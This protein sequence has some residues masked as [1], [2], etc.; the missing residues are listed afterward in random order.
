MLVAQIS[1]LNMSTF[2]KIFVLV[3]TV[4]GRRLQNDIGR[5][6]DADDQ[7]QNSFVNADSNS[8]RSLA[9]SHRRV[10]AAGVV[11]TSDSSAFASFLLS[12]S[13]ATSSSRLGHPVAA[14]TVVVDS[15]SRTLD[16]RLV[17]DDPEFVKSMLRMR[18]SS[19]E[20]LEI[21]DRIG[22]LTR[23]RSD[24]VQTGDDARK[25]RKQLSGQI[26]ACMKSGD[27]EQAEA[28]KVQVSEAAQTA[29]DADEKLG[30]LDSERSALFASLPN[31]LDPR[32]EDGDDE[33]SN[34][35]VG[36]WGVDD[37]QKDR[38]W[39]DEFG[40]ELGGIDL[41]SAAKI[42][43]SRFSVLR[44]GLAKL[45]RSLINFFLDTHTSENGYTEVMV[46]YI[47]GSEALRGTGQLPKFE[48]DLFK[49]SE[50]VNGRDSFLIPT[51][52]VPVTNLHAN[53]IIEERMLPLSY[54]AFTPCFRAEAGSAG[55]DTR[56]LFRQH[57]FHK[58]ELVKIT[59][60]EQSDEEHHKMVDHAEKLLQ[61]LKLPYRK[62][63]LCSGDIGFSAR[64][65]YDIEVW[66]PGQGKFREISSLS[67][68]A[69]FQ[70]RRM[71]MRYRPS[72]RD[73]KGKNKKTC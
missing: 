16:E 48:E 8:W 58:V 35:E 42:S 67:N 47:V 4:S 23:G 27:K 28:L 6:T 72:E 57:Q 3:C 71:N 10:D 62:V 65:C 18:R 33:D 50:P 12:T 49:L 70:A 31:L 38:K 11:D 51:A 39:H 14:D 59:T 46:P 15:P 44:G 13:P 53:E 73:E 54:C 64:M 69:D 9:G 66:L 1:S 26:G 25:V 45:E 34:V 41:E 61:A 63:R 21:V 5:L 68:C 2:C 17:A 7:E 43:G 36:T 55:R 30:A 56:G 20:L 24:L 40:T 29:A 19:D 22:E 32:T 37:L 52:E 60:P